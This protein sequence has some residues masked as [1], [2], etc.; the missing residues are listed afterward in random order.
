MT[1]KECSMS[2]NRNVVPSQGGALKDLL[3]KI[4]LIARLMAD[5]RV[6]FWAK[7]LPIG[8]LAYV[9][10]PI[11]LVPGAALP[12]VGALDDVAI[13]WLGATMFI[14][15]CPPEVVAELSEGLYPREGAQDPGS[16]VIDAEVTDVSQEENK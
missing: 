1:E 15:L 5:R 13:L 12:V 2:N 10:S 4:K 6:S 14:E 8:A 11:D 3:K 9:I 16:D 7:L